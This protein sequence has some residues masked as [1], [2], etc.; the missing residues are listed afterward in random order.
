MKKILLFFVA[1]MMSAGLAL[2]QNR[3]ISGKITDAS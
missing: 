3:E 1:I 2:A